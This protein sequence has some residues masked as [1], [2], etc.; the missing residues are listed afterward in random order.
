MESNFAAISEAIHDFQNESLD[1]NKKETLQGTA[2]EIN[3]R[4]SEIF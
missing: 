4:F 3:G 2:G 1:W